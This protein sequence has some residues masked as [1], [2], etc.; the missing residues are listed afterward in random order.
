MYMYIEYSSTNFFF[1][2]CFSFS[3]LRDDNVSERHGTAGDVGG[4]L[5]MEGTI[6]EHVVLDTVVDVRDLADIKPATL[7]LEVLHQF[8][9]PVFHEM[10]AFVLVEHMTC[11]GNGCVSAKSNAHVHVLPY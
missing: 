10:E 2:F 11:N 3:Y 6:V 1:T 8:S 9:P 5:E 7:G 4:R